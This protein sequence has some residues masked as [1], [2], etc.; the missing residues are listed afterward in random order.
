V[1]DQPKSILY[2]RPDT[3][4]DLVI[5]SGAVRELLE[6]WPEAQHTLL[7]RPGYEG[8]APLFPAKLRWQVCPINPFT[9]KPGEARQAFDALIEQIKASAPDL[10]VASTL[11][12][13]WLETAVASRFPQARRVS[14]GHHAVDPLFANAL[15]LEFGIETVDA[16]PEAVS[17]DETRR[18]WENN[19]RL[20]EQLIGH[21]RPAL[22][23]ALQ[24]PDAAR[25]EADAQLQTLGLA[26]QQ[27]VL[28]FAGGLANVPIKAWP[29][30]KFGDLIL[31]LQKNQPHPIVVAGH[32]SETAAIDEVLA[33]AR[34]RG[35]RE[36]ARWLGRD[37]QI[38][39]LA[40]M[41]EASVFY[42]GHDTGAMH[43]AAAVG[44]P[45]VGIFGGGHWPRFRPVGQ[46]VV[47]VVQPLPCFG[48]NWDCIFGDA[49]CVKT[50]RP[51]D[52]QR[53]VELILK[54][55]ETVDEIVEAQH[56]SSETLRLISA[57]KPRYSAL[58]SDRLQRQHRIEELKNETDAKDV[59]IAE[60]KTETD[61]KDLEIADLKTAAEERKRE[62]ESIKA[63]LEAECAEKDGE[64]AELKSEADT[65]DREIDDL[66]KVCNEREQL[67]ITLDGHIKNFQAMVAQLRDESTA[68]DTIIEARTRELKT[69]TQ[70]LAALQATFAK[71]PADAETWAKIFNDKDVHI[72]NLDTM[73][74]ARAR[75]LAAAE[76]TIAN[77]AAGHANLE[78]VKYYNKLLAEK[79]TVIQSLD[80]ACK[81]REKVIQQ[82]ALEAA[83]PAGKLGK[84]WFA[85]RQHA[86]LK[87]WLPLNDWFF[88]RAVEKYWMKIGVL[89]HYAPRPL[90]WDRFPKAKLPES[91]LPKIGIV[92]PSY[93]Q[94]AFIESTML[95][96]LNQ[97]YPKLHYVVQ[98]GGSKD[99]SPQIIA[100]YADQLQHWESVKDKGQADAIR[101]GFQ[102]LEGMLGPDDVMA[103]LN[104]DDLIA[105]RTLRFVA[106]YFAK[107]PTVD[108]IY[109]HRII[110]D[111][112]DRDVGRWIMPRHDPKTLEW[113]D[114]VP[115][116][117]LFWRKR[118]WDKVGGID[119]SFQFALDWDLIARFQLAHAR[120][121]R[122]PYFLGCF[123]VH[124][125]QKTSQHIHTVGSEEMALI[126]SRFHGERHNDFETINR[127]AR[128][129][130]LTG[131]LTARLA[132]WGIRY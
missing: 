109:G 28:V 15:K 79:E 7:V 30:S 69:R 101:R 47:S 129:A 54:S 46:K 132:A 62:M 50:L 63:E 97:K 48:C 6:E 81:E 21:T 83:G 77:Y 71:L 31:W 105:P 125:E 22:A 89:D 67:I 20:V 51:E 49:P 66:K 95:S 9:Q 85:T 42:V 124:A 1:P 10:I 23:P 39:L 88:D 56:F 70:E 18:D 99:A 115:Q 65:K 32:V 40:A 113:I 103:W 126:R 111:G 73:L 37:G 24:L 14:L 72:R 3:I 84:L 120:I 128:K 68:K 106:E 29:Y 123:R 116:E 94:A 13:T 118:V 96:V 59:E 8:L 102:H 76:A 35:A 57:V 60:L 93:G 122:V 12:R 38:P 58:Q 121:V 86:R 98:D 34:A 25:A 36:P 100:R 33:Q 107:N 117:T 26:R 104:S 43:I 11:N 55:P 27:Y 91:K 119:P 108:V 52:V 130:R 114:Y 112:N 5:F 110:I 61:G 45:T 75:Q 80:R 41:L 82:L 92:T 131:A 78:Q 16:F 64:I 127:F 19:H 4:G 87:W 90:K 2:I 74:A 17:V 53:A 44:R